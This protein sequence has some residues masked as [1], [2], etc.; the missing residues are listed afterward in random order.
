MIVTLPDLIR[1][2]AEKTPDNIA[3]FYKDEAVTYKELYKKIAELGQRFLAMGLKEQD[4]AA[5]YLPNSFDAAL[6]CFAAAYAGIVFVPINPSLKS[7]QVRHILTDCNVRLMITSPSRLLALNKKD[8]LIEK[9]LCIGKEFDGFQ[10]DGRG[11]KKPCV[12][13]KDDIAAIF[14]TS[15]STGSP[16]GVVLS[17]DNMV[18]GALSVA[19]YLRHSPDDRILSI[20][21]FSFDAGFS[22]LTTV[23]A[24]GASVVIMNY[25]MPSDVLKMSLK[26]RVTGITLVPPLWIKLSTLEW[27]Q[28][29]SK[30]IRYIATTGGR[31]PVQITKKLSKKLPTSDIYLMYGLTEA[32]RSTYLDPKEIKTRPTSIGKAIPQADIYIL[33]ADGKIC[34]AG[35]VGELVHAG[36]LVS[37]GY[38]GNKAKTD[39]K[40]KTLPRISFPERCSE[41][42][43]WSGD[44]V[45]RDKEGFLYFV[46]RTDEMIKT[47]GYRVSPTEVE[48][49]MISS[50]YIVEAVAVG[51]SN[52]E[53]GQVIHAAVS[54]KK[55][56]GEC[57]QEAELLKY[58]RENMPNYMVPKKIIQTSIFH[59]PNGK[60]DRKATSDKMMSLL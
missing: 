6:S 19:S 41:I 49:I 40:F 31:M 57:F 47:S 53:L 42:A 25:L 27:S 14:Y 51:V 9:S 36:V 24:V 17:H 3:I 32:F 38:W 5:I 44:M 10:E 43:V 2:S 37:K 34:K 22:Q 8:I 16:K 11:F 58:C 20:L 30:N 46:G 28:E 33:R 60:I 29:I 50:G 12:L 1:N 56:E 59:N 21:P 23:F 35:E 13:S 26:H 52:D 55:G 7:E 39:E 18:Q 54:A 45:K 15:G 48:E 4:R